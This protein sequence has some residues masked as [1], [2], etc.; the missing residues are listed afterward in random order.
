MTKL[1]T[2][3]VPELCRAS[4]DTVEELFHWFVSYYEQ[5]SVP[6]NYVSGTRCVRDAYKG[7]HNLDQLLA[8]CSKEK[9]PTGRKCNEEIVALAAPVAFER[10]VMV[11]DLSH[12]RFPFA[13]DKRAAFRVPFFFNE[14]GV[15]KL[16]HLQPR[17][18]ASPTIEQLGM[19]ATIYKRFLLD[20]E[21]YGLRS[22]IEIVD[23]SVK[24]G[25][26]RQMRKYSLADLEIWSDERLANRLS[27]IGE[28][29][30]L[31]AR[32][33]L[34]KPRPML[35]SKAPDMPLFD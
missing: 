31:V 18:F 30:E 29:L 1:P 3:A 11:F 16:Y 28:A 2:P 5:G 15:V 22:D 9:N 23:L 34:I 14:D 26:S 35:P 19:Q 4:G 32:S 21:F 6:W 17:K 13:R 24:G 20:T 7:Y 10:S 33:G 8:G 12:R 25:R 27:L